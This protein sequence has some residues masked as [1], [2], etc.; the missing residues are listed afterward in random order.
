MTPDKPEC[1]AKET[2]DQEVSWVDLSIS[3]HPYISNVDALLSLIQEL[4]LKYVIVE[5]KS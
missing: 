2:S 3:L 4:R 5:R 1:P